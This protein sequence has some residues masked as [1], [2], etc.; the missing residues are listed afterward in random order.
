MSEASIENARGVAMNFEDSRLPKRFWGKCIPEPNSSCWFWLGAISG[1]Y[2]QLRWPEGSVKAK[3]VSVHRIAVMADGRLIPD[4]YTIDHRCENTCCANPAHL[5][6]VTNEEN[7]ARFWRRHPHTRCVHGHL[8]RE[9]GIYVDR[10]GGK[11]CKRCVLAQR[12]AK[13]KPQP[14]APPAP[15]MWRDK[16]RKQSCVHGHVRSAE[17]VSSSGNC[18][19]CDRERYRRLS[20]AARKVEP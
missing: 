18:R 7:I 10:S 6:V 4:G 20:D 16:P 8:L 13:Y 2:G 19:E 5:D 12:R 1:G 15:F 17:N 9:V 3:R 11:H 14:K